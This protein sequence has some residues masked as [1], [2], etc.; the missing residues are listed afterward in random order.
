MVLHFAGR[1]LENGD[2]GNPVLPPLAAK[3]PPT[4]RRGLRSRTEATTQPHIGLG[5]A[6]VP[7]PGLRLQPVAPLFS[8]PVAE[9]FLGDS[10]SRLAAA[11]GNLA[12]GRSALHAMPNNTDALGGLRVGDAQLSPADSCREAARL[13]AQVLPTS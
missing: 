13:L 3:P 9:P 1:N 6:P 5:T 2:A 12:Q 8:V 11:L 7:D 10:R 4:P